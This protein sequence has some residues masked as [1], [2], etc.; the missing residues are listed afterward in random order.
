MPHRRVSHKP[1]DGLDFRGVVFDPSVGGSLL[2][3]PSLDWGDIL[4]GLAHRVFVA[5]GLYQ[6]R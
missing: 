3:N 2:G 1:I 4:A 5:S 6:L